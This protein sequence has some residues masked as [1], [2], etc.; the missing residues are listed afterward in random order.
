MQSQ[1]LTLP[2]ME[3]SQSHPGAARSVH[4]HLQPRPSLEGCTKDQCCATILTQTA[5][6]ETGDTDVHTVDSR[7]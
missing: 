3:F 1:L 7:V 4:Q 5:A 6:R 2:R